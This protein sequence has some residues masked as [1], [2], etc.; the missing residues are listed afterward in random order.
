M[1]K[2]INC[3]GRL[4]D[5]ST[6]AIM[7]I[8]N[9]TADSFYASSRLS[10]SS[11]AVEQAVKM[12]GEGATILDIGGQSS[13]P[14]AEYLS[15][16]TEWSNLEKGLREIRK[17][18]PDS[19]LS[20]DTFHADVARRA[21][22]EGA[23]LINDISG[24]TMDEQMFRTIADLQIP[25]ILSHIRGT[26]QTMHLKPTYENLLSEV[27][28]D[29]QKKLS[30]LLELGVF[31]VL[32]DPGFGFGKTIQHNF[33]LLKQLSLFHILERP[34]VVG[35]S[36][37]SMIYKTLNTD[38]EHAGN[39]TTVLNTIALL[40]GASVLRVHDV[41]EASEAIKLVQQYSGE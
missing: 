36:R 40:N 2:S 34:V 32:I 12:S 6:P 21:A 39:G 24:G 41:R 7:G 9:F 30:A 4:L 8:L 13:R 35:L 29:L 25:Y 38:T 18:L 16:E 26:P 5:F 3:R 23:D 11:A 37:K 10:N 17:E 22:G 28:D 33:S 14:G 1:K 31:D 20:V 15:A 27:L 19:I